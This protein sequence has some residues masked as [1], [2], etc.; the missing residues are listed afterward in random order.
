[1][2]NCEVL[3]ASPSLMSESDGTFRFLLTITWMTVIYFAS[4]TGNARISTYN[5]NAQ[6]FKNVVVV[7][8]VATGI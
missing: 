7:H 3:L 2:E 6:W 1:M 4:C 5:P 8:C